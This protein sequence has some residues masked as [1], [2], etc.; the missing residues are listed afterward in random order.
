[1]DAIVLAAGYGTRLYP[2]TLDRPKALL[3]VGGRTILD[4]LIDKIEH[5]KECDTIFV[6]TNSKFYD[7]FK[8]WAEAKNIRIPIDIIDDGTES[9]KTR[10]GAIGDINLVLKKKNIKNDLCIFGSDNLFEDDLKDFIE[11][12]K[13]KIPFSSIV[14]FDV[15]D[16]NLAKKYGVCTL[17]SEHIVVEFEEKPEIPRSTL[18]AGCM[19]FIPKEKIGKV[20]EYMTTQLPKDAPG[21]LVRYLVEKDRVYGYILKGKWYD[22]GDKRSL[23]RAD[24]DFRERK[25]I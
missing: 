25:G 21:N 22:I 4:R 17:D 20:Q 13:D 2:L 12:S 23:D 14:L 11:F 10:L 16:I 7:V 18:A 15:G 8:K 1:M 3:E 5:L 6:V 9:N 19:Y 24:N